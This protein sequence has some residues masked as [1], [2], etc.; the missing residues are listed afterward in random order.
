L[1]VALLPPLLPLLPLLLFHPGSTGP[2]D[3]EAPY[4][5][6]QTLIAL[7][8]PPVARRGYRLFQSAHDTKCGCA[9]AH[10]NKSKL[11]KKYKYK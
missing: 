3:G 9:C 7:S 1:S 4:E 6:G 2:S 10:Q 11:I 8:T 5:A